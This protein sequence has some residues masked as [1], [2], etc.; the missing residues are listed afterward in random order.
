MRLMLLFLLGW[1][2][3]ACPCFGQQPVQQQLAAYMQAQ[4][5]VN[6]FA[7]VVLVTRHDTVLLKQAYGL[8]DYEWAVPNTPDTRFSLA[9]ITKQFTAVAILQLAERGQLRLS[10]KLSAF[11]PGFPNG[12][13]IT[14]HMLLTHTAGLALDFEEMYL[15]HTNV[16]KDSA[17][18]YIQ[19]LPTRFAP[20]TA[21]GLQ[22]RGLLPAGAGY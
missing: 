7:G 20:G 4:H 10:D 5:D 15:A 9:S 11:I 3:I 12:N 19:R 22:Q 6:H 21:I 13:N 16:S 18:A 17:L 14:L 2:A 8:A 1:G